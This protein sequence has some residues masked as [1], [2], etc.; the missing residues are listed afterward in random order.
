MFFVGGSCRAAYTDDI[1]SHQCRS[2]IS[3][4]KNFQTKYKHDF[5]L[6]LIVWRLVRRNGVKNQTKEK[7][8]GVYYSRRSGV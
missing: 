2:A 8:S 7:A 1:L 3:L 6:V 4:E 5:F